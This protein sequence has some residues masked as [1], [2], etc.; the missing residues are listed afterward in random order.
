M[1]TRDQ[2][3]PLVKPGEIGPVRSNQR[4]PVEQSFSSLSPGAIQEQD[5]APRLSGKALTKELAFHQRS[6]EEGAS[7]EISTDPSTSPTLTDKGLR[8]PFGRFGERNR[9]RRSAGTTFPLSDPIGYRGT[10]GAGTRTASGDPCT[11]NKGGNPDR[12]A[13]GCGA[14]SGPGRF[15][16][17]AAMELGIPVVTAALVGAGCPI[18][19]ARLFLPWGA[20]SFLLP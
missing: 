6:Q 5:R 9:R 4:L 19:P 2:R 20:M 16:G 11:D 7:C 8:G 17:E 12:C 14:D 18:L 10:I 1:S 13:A 3:R 15:R